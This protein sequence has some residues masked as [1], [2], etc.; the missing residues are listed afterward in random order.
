MADG[1]KHFELAV[2]L[3][4]DALKAL[5]VVNG[6]AATALI[7]LMDKSSNSKDYTPAI[8]LFAA[9]AAW[10]VVSACFGYMSQLHYAN[11]RMDGSRHSYRGHTTWQIAAI[12]SVVLTLTFMVSGIIAAAVIARPQI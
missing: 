3:S 4:R 11:H 12:I 7:A 10:A 1:E 5:L 6:G 8:L 2:E 9:G